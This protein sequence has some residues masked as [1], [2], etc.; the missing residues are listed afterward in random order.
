M[1]LFHSA[2]STIPA[3]TILCTVLYNYFP[4]LH[5][6]SAAHAAANALAY[7]DL[8]LLLL[9]PE[10]YK[11]VHIGED[12]WR[13]GT[14]QPSPK[15]LA[16]VPNSPNTPAGDDPW[17]VARAAGNSASAA[18]SA[19]IAALQCAI[20]RGPSSSTTPQA[21][22]HASPCGMMHLEDVNTAPRLPTAGAERGEHSLSPPSTGPAR[23]LGLGSLQLSPRTPGDRLSPQPQARGGQSFLQLVVRGRNLVVCDDVWEVLVH[24]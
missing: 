22:P 10:V 20:R 9:G 15:L 17:A 23:G 6:F 2:G 14:V 13:S 7:L 3:H 19:A 24:C 11:A 1:S 8:S 12:M 5:R 4:L 18:V 21:S 16:A